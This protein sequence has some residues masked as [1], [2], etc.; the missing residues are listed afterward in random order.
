VIQDLQRHRNVIG[1]LRH[2]CPGDPF[3]FVEMME[4]AL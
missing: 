4:S 1:H 2:R 3:I